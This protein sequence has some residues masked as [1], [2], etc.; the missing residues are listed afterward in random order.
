[1][2]GTSLDSVKSKWNSFK[3]TCHVHDN[4]SLLFR[5]LERYF[6]TKM[7]FLRAKKMQ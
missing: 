7:F 3:V 5:S 1:M 4:S 6:I 2:L